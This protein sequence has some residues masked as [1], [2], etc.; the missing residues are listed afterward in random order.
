MGSFTLSLVVCVVVIVKIWVSWQTHPV[1]VTFD[2][3]TTPISTIPF[4]AM[5]IC[6]SQ[7][8][9]ENIT[10]IKDDDGFEELFHGE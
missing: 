6:T 10:K 1:I 4:P 8:I 9:K 7:K 3:K 5:T 2:D